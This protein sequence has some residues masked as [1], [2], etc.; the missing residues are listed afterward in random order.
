MSG[1]TAEPHSPRRLVVCIHDATPA[2]DRETRTMIRDLTPLL[3]RRLSFG[4]IPDWRGEWP[5]AAHRDYCRFVQESSGELLLHGYFHQRQ[6]GRGLITCLTAGGDEMNG[7]EPDATRRA[8]DL[9]QRVFADAFGERAR[10]FIAPAWQRG[11]VR[12]DAANAGG[13]AHVLG[14]FSLD[15]RQGRRIPLAT[16]SWDCGRWACLGYVGQHFGQWLQRLGNRVPTLAIHPRDLERG[17]WPT[18]VRLTGEL[19]DAG[20]EPVTPAELIDVDADGR[21]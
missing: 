19:L 2:H 16:S 11:H 6:H 12:L 15:T 9:G 7:L 1:P 10:G 18:I 21:A 5:L 13:L 14:Y 8:V 17:F 4:V 20:F 3:G